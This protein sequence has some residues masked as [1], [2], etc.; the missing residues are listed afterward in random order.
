MGGKFVCEHSKS[1][2]VTEGPHMRGEVRIG[3]DIIKCLKL[4]DNGAMSEV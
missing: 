1:D 2:K 3:D 4:V